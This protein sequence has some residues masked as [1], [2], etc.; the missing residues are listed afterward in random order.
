MG[1]VHC[2][3]IVFIADMVFIACPPD[4]LF[5]CLIG[6]FGMDLKRN[7]SKFLA[8]CSVSRPVFGT[9]QLFYRKVSQ[10][11]RKWEESESE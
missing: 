6:T 8:F 1:Y 11:E 5:V 10:E 2:Y 4:V 9:K 3:G 7:R